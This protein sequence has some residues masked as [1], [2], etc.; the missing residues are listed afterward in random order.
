MIEPI[1]LA[2]A[3]P[4]AKPFNEGNVSST[5]RGQILRPNGTVAMAVLKD[6]DSKELA[7]ELLASVLARAVALPTPEAFLTLVPA[8]VMEMTKGPSTADGARL[9]F[10]SVD[11]GVPNIQFR[12][13]TDTVGRN[14][15]IAGVT[16]WPELGRLYGYDA[17]IANVDR[18]A[19]NL[20]FSSGGEA[21]LIDHGYSFTGP[22]WTVQD[23]VPD[24]DYANRLAEWVSP[25]LTGEGRLMRV[26]Q[27][28]QLQSDLHDFNAV[29]AIEA[30]RAAMFLSPEDS[31]PDRGS[32]DS[33]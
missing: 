29:E 5:F 1:D 30:S 9:A 10:A 33:L 25:A 16:S 22:N 27:A 28:T 4:G 20:L 23:L 14:D 26:R 31:R 12:Y 7:N 13:Q 6:L 19:G 21:W 15:L 18:H 3:L 2:R 32:A 17:W 11:V 8:D 24:R